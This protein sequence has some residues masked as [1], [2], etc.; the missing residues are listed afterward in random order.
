MTS[1]EDMDFRFRHVLAVAFRLAEIEREIVFA[2]D[3]IFFILTFFR[4]CSRRKR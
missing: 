2:L 3:W 1:A 4:L